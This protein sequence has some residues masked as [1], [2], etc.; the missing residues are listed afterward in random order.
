MSGRLVAEAEDSEAGFTERNHVLGD[1][2]VR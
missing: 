1:S 2:N